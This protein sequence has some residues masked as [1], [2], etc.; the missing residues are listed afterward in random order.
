MGRDNRKKSR[1][2][3]A[4]ALGIRAFVCEFET[5]EAR[6]SRD[7]PDVFGAFAQLAGTQNR[8]V[9]T[10][11]IHQ[12]RFRWRSAAWMCEPGN[13]DVWNGVGDMHGRADD[14]PNRLR[15]A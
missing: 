5:L 2:M 9:P 15:L 13:F 4:H 8:H 3:D 10:Y 6:R 11:I 1:R 12:F 14:A 7:R